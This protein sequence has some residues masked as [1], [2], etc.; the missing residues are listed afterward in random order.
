MKISEGNPFGNELKSAEGR[1]KSVL[2][3]S[4]QSD[5]DTAQKK[6]D[7][8]MNAAKSYEMKRHNKELK[9]TIDDDDIDSRGEV[10][11]GK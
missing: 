6:L 10:K 11:V 1:L 9:E 5:I 8:V 3:G 4:N 2:D 7:N